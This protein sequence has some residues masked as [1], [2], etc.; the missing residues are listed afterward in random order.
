MYGTEGSI[1]TMKPHT[2]VLGIDDGPFTFQQKGCVFAGVML[3]LPSYIESAAFGKVTV[4]GTD[5]TEK[6]A[7]IIDLNG[8]K[9]LLHAIFIDG[10]ALAGFNIVDIGRLNELTKIPV[11]TVT[12]DRPNIEAIKSAIQSHFTEWEERYGML[13][14]REMHEITTGDGHLYISFSGTDLKGAKE[15]VRA[16]ILRGHTPEPLR[17]AHMIARAFARSNK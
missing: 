14:R 10:A 5:S 8:W 12:A 2:R 13:A 6:I 15:V 17:L 1:I 11:I 4:D 16:S 7:E 3:R 9:P